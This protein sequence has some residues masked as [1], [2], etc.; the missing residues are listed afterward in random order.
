MTKV[1]GGHTGWRSVSPKQIRLV[2]LYE[3]ERGVQGEYQLRM[4]AEL[5]DAARSQGMTRT[6]GRCP[7]KGVG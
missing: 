3:E 1:R 2:S 4:A 7:E 5:G 6:V